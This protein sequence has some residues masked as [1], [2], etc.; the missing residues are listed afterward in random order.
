MKQHATGDHQA[1]AV[2]TVPAQQRRDMVVFGD[3]RLGLP[4]QIAHAA[5]RFHSEFGIAPTVV[6]L[7]SADAPASCPGRLAGVPVQVLAHLPPGY[8]WLHGTVPPAVPEQPPAA[9]GTTT[10]T[11]RPAQPRRQ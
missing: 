1:G 11:R 9:T 4:Q 5:T 2:A 7:S 6:R 8:F 10:R 3:R